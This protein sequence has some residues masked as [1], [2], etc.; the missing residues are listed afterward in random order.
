MAA[1]SKNLQSVKFP[2]K[3]GVS[4]KAIEEMINELKENKI[5]YHSLMILRHGKIA[6]EGHRYPFGRDVPHAM[7]SVSKSFVSVAIGFAI[8]EGLIS[9]DT[10]VIDIFPA[11]RLMKQD[12]K[13]EK[14]TV[15]H[16][17]TMTSGK[18]VSVFSDKT[19]YYWVK[20]F[21]ASKWY[22]EPGQ[23]WKYISENTYMCAAIIQ[24]VTGMG[25]REYLKPRLFEPLGFDRM[26]QWETDR[27]GLEAGGWGLY[28]TPLE[29]AKFTL[30]MQQG[31]M[32]AGKQ[33][34]PQWYAEDAVKLHTTCKQNKDADS[35]SGY[36][37]FFW[38]SSVPNC[39]RADGMFSQFGI[40]FKDYDACLIF[41]GSEVA[42][43]KVKRIIFKHFPK[44]FVEETDEKSEEEYKFDF[45]PMYVLPENKRSVMEKFIEGKKIK[46]MKNPVLNAA[47]FPVSV[48]SFPAVYMSADKC[49]NINDVVFEFLEDE[50][51]FS[52][53][54][55]EVRN[56]IHCGMDGK[57]RESKMHLMGID[58]TAYSTAA[59]S[60]DGALE[61]LIRPIETI[62][63]RMLRFEFKGKNVTVYP[64]TLPSSGEMLSGFT[65]GFGEM[66]PGNKPAGI[67][68]KVSGRAGIV[69]DQPLFGKIH[70]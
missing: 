69:L 1:K 40:M 38:M 8:D 19:S 57:A 13:I 50:C 66:L 63:A 67:L 28:I 45:S 26:P 17:L 59:W 60:F 11:Y 15:Y 62:N 41:T 70:V 34:I 9:Y 47:G 43:Q 35:S 56:T 20:D 65:E 64:D 55:G 3:L 10:K 44:G 14:L 23:K 4:S 49:G 27:E 42:E 53:T 33:V 5:E 7:Y 25:V 48:L 18:D 21:F 6:F 51:V 32:Y 22:A 31:G 29:L 2:E 61:L 58:F 30:C 16:L 46:F 12:E 36:G 39:P 54:E 52:W 68:R 37:L 24:K